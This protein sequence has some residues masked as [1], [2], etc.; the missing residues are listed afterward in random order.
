[1]V[2][3]VFSASLCG[4]SL[5]LS[6]SLSFCVF[7][8]FISVCVY[9][10]ISLSVSLSVSLPPPRLYFVPAFACTAYLRGDVDHIDANG[11]VP[12]PRTTSL[13]LRFWA[14]PGARIGAHIQRNRRLYVGVATFFDC[15]QYVWNALLV[16]LRLEPKTRHRFHR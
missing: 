11:S 12:R 2:P 3:A 10:S 6:L 5:F 1:M 16:V 4:L 7:L 14:G 15:C 8:V 13:C 9:L